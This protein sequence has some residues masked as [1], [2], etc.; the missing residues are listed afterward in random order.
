M[1]KHRDALWGM[2][3]DGSLDPKRLAS[4]LLGYLSDDECKEFAQMNDI[5]LFP[6]EEEEE[7]E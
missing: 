4:D 2:L 1:A 3:E 6:D 7:E 5:A